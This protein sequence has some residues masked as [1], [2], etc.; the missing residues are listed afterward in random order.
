MTFQWDLVCNDTW[1]VDFAG[2]AVILGLLLGALVNGV[3]AERYKLNPSMCYVYT[4]TYI[5]TYS[6]SPTN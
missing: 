6:I 2:S 1:K 3:I 4:K 5:N